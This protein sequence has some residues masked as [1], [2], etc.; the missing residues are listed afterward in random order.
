MYDGQ[1]LFDRVTSAFGAE[2]RVDE[3][4]GGL[5]LEGRL[6][7][8]IVVAIDNS[9]A[10]PCEYAPFASDPHPGCAD[11]TTLGAAT[12]AFL[13]ETLKPWVDARY[14]TL[15]DRAHTAVAGASMGGQLALHAALTHPQV[16][17]KAAALSPSFQN[18]RTHP[19]EMPGFVRALGAQ[20]LRAWLD[21]GDAETIRDLDAALLLAN[22]KSV[23]GA[24]R[25]AGAD[26][27]EVV[28][29][30]GEHHER[31][32]AAR[33]GDVVAWLWATP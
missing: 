24:L 14:P 1:N 30:S 29:P 31:A 11:G 27:R 9:D 19:L 13:V 5:V 10:R 23:A 28:V 25:E 22:M 20:G 32:W 4:V 26:V 17:S 7:P 15:P 12:N 21:M 2:W 16:F 18:V 3:T 33:F 8:V 6:A